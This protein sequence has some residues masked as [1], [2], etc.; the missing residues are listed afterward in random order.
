M[1][2]SI[3]IPRRCFMRFANR[4]K[5]SYTFLVVLFST[6]FIAGCVAK[7]A[8]RVEQSGFLGDYSQFREAK[9]NEALYVYVNPKANCR[10]YSKVIIDPVALWAKSEDSPLA[11]LDEK[12]QKMLA[13]RGW[14]TIYDAMRK[15]DFAIVSQPETDVMRV[16]AAVT[17]A[18]K[19]KVML[20]NALA[21]APYAW[22][23]ATLWGMGTGKWPFLG[24]LASEMEIVDSLTGERL[25]AGVDKVSGTMGSNMDPRARWDDVRKGFDHW[26]EKIGKRMVSCRETGSFEMPKDDR[27]WMKKTFDYMAP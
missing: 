19:A 10:K 17:E 9:E 25:M 7:Q 8:R 15:A 13:T 12:D 24:E 22:Q 3:L 27:T 6:L 2:L 5:I 4:H 16:R 23:A 26:R 14:G 18:T 1:C 11:E 21:V 20:A